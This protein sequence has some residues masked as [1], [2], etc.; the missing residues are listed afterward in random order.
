MEK[1]PTEPTAAM[2]TTESGLFQ[3]CHF[4]WRKAYNAQSVVCESWERQIEIQI[5]GLDSDLDTSDK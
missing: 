4:V 3:F 2:M 5:I 1:M